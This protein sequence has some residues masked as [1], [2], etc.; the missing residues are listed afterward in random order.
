MARISDSVV[1]VS[2]RDRI[3][4]AWTY[5]IC[6]TPPAGGIDP[7][8]LWAT[9]NGV[10]LFS[11][12]KVDP[13]KA[14]SVAL[15]LRQALGVPSHPAMP[16]RMVAWIEDPT[17]PA[18]V[19]ALYGSQSAPGIFSI[20]RTWTAAWG[21]FQL[22]VG[23]ALTLR[24]EPAD[25]LPA[26]RLSAKPRDVGL[27]AFSVRGQPLRIGYSHDGFDIP[28]RLAGAGAGS[29]RIAVGIDPSVLIEAFRCGFVYAPGS[30]PIPFPMVR[31][32]RRTVNNYRPFD[33]WLNPIRPLD[34]NCTRFSIDDRGALARPGFPLIKATAEAPDL[35]EAPYF[36]STTG[37]PVTLRPLDPGA[38]EPDAMAGGFAFS[39]EVVGAANSLY[40]SPCGLWEVAEA[41]PL[42]R[43]MAGV[44]GS[45][46]L[47]LRP[48]DRLLFRANQ[49][50]T[51][52]SSGADAAGGGV[53]TLGGPGTTSW[54]SVQPR[55]SPSPAYF[56]QASASS[57]FG[58]A[59]RPPFPPALDVQLAS[60]SSPS[61][62]FPLVPYGGVYRPTP[63]DRHTHYPPPFEG[64]PQTLLQ[65]EAAVLGN[66][67][68][69]ILTATSRGPVLLPEGAVAPDPRLDRATTSQGLL[70][71]LGA[72][73][74][75]TRLTLAQS[76][77]YPG[78]QPLSLSFEAAAGDVL[79]PSLGNV[80]T[81]DQA[82]LVISTLPSDMGG[83][84]FNNRLDLAGFNLLFDVGKAGGAILVFKF[85]T[86]ASLKTLA[87]EPSA[88]ADA[89]IFNADAGAASK[90]L[91][92][93]IADAQTL[94]A[95]EE[96]P[97]TADEPPSNDHVDSFA[98]FNA[99][100]GEEDWTGV[101]AFDIQ[102]DGNGMPPGLQILLGGI[103]GDLR[104]HHVGVQANRIEAGAKGQP[105]LTLVDSAL[106]GVIHYQAP[107]N[108]APPASYPDYQVEHLRIAWSNSKVVQS[109]V[110]IGVT[111]ANLFGRPI[112]MRPAP[113]QAA[114]DPAP[115]NTLQIAGASQT[116][117]GID[118]VTFSSDTP[119]IFDLQP[120]DKP[121]NAVRVLQRVEIDRANLVPLRSSQTAPTAP[122]NV[123]LHLLM[124]GQLFFTQY[125]FPGAAGKIDLFSYG[126]KSGEGMAFTGLAVEIAFA[127]DPVQGSMVTNSKSVTLRED[128]LTPVPKATALRPDSFLGCFPA[129]VSAFIGAPGGLPSAVPDAQPIH[130][131]QLEPPP[132]RGDAAGAAPPS[133]TVAPIWALE[134][135]IHLGSLGALSDDHAGLAA[136]LFIGWGPSGSV[137]DDDAAGMLMVLPHLA[138]GVAGFSLQGLLKTTFDDGNLL[139]VSLEG[140]PV[141]VIT[142]ANVH[143][144]F[145]GFDF[146]P[147]T[148]ADFT[149]FAGAPGTDRKASNLAWFLAARQTS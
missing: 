20:R 122:T 38:A 53:E 75:I 74:T 1:L 88:W 39:N 109:D 70:L 31:P 145:M 68:H 10:L 114:F 146:P 78:V 102:I 46:F 62:L 59:D 40:L 72:D 45:E 32:I 91:V 83:A 14:E 12:T 142:F 22:S 103:Q 106:F 96:A 99:L 24:F 93:L 85:N 118:T 41:A 97:Q 51:A 5:Y 50:G 35:L 135:D 57:F 56:G 19:S 33:V 98:T 21:Q 54:V 7:A 119:F 134:Y 79:P 116:V 137:P 95:A 55:A 42:Q 84:K 149:I 126:S 29:L 86:R 9:A 58:S 125:P 71:D 36:C 143:L 34:D 6:E 101:L 73:G 4:A 90:R 26:L 18:T 132:A 15:G 104:A 110:T 69:E 129:Q 144:S 140:G 107:I 89:D 130:I 112:W 115:A 67:R 128:L 63:V 44:F 94:G 117:D 76:P 47:L 120:P 37:D 2:G 52:V 87:A 138:G 148:M 8:T 108:E 141:Y 113:A 100:A 105:S 11:N 111:F 77:A 136:K 124:D 49:P 139:R 23:P 28:I 64:S 43:L 13:T 3:Q 66:T 131:L 82:F 61:A 30:R 65:F 133:T 80:L 123:T 25:E 81:R 16:W 127:L 121:S 147:R 92:Q 17:V 48:G 27:I 60:F